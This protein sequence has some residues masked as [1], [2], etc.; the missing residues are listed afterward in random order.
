M[1]RWFASTGAATSTPVRVLYGVR[2]SDLLIYRATLD[3][4]AKRFPDLGWQAYL[5]EGA[6]AGEHPG[7]L[8]VEAALGAAHATGAAG[9]ATFYVSGPP[10]MLAVFQ[11]GL[12]AAGVPPS[13]VR[14]DAWD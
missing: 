11:S 8:S 14:A 9:A 5:E 10:A 3:E 4:A 1:E 7:R 6:G 13:R 12:G 2:R